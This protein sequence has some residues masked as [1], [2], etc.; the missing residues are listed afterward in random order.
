MYEANLVDQELDIKPFSY[1]DETLD[2]L[3]TALSRARPSTYL[4][5]AGGD[6][7]R[8]IRLHAWNT[9]RG[10]GIHTRPQAHEPGR[11]SGVS[12]VWVAREEENDGAARRGQRGRRRPDSGCS[13][14]EK[15]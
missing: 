11:F 13:L 14:T 5:A 12:F 6:R 10:F 8:A 3:E 9:T 15:R 2:E 7:E 1:T 4:D